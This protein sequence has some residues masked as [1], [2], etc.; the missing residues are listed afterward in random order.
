MVP[1]GDLG[2]ERVGP[3]VKVMILAAGEGRRML[4][5]TKET[6]KPL[7]PVRGKPLLEHH[8]ERLREAGFT[9]FV[10]NA[11]YLGDQVA[12]FCSDG[13]RWEVSIRISRESIPLE[14]A[15]GIIQALPDLGEDPFA[16][17][18]GDIFTDFPFANPEHHPAGD[19]VLTGQRLHQPP[20]MKSR[21]K[22][23]PLTFT[24][25]GIA[26]YDPAFF[27]GLALGKRPLKPL[28]DKAIAEGRLTGQCYR[29]LWSDVGTPERL[30]AL[31][32]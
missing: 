25:S 16:V 24:F 11:A 3:A 19:F 6:P 10:V 20:S 7:L 29:G 12:A 32:R 4:P 9:D 14:T 30:A 26:L 15:G 13:R 17:V 2:G 31:N 1:T 18:N 8:I 22:S 27:A 21:D 23:S 28:L 5:L